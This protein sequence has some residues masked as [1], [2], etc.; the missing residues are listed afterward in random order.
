LKN[1]TEMQRK[2]TTSYEGYSQEENAPLLCTCYKS[3]HSKSSH[4]L[5]LVFLNDIINHD[6]ITE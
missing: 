4:L 6:K 5:K 3:S 2:Q 1:S